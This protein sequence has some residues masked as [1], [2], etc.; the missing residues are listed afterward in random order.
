MNDFI[1]Q[2]MKDK[3][4]NYSLREAVTLVFVAATL[5]SWLAQQFFSVAVPEYMFYSFVSIIGAGCFGYSIEK[6]TKTFT[7]EKNENP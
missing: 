2:L 3:E 4:G 1:K 6:K 7:N 5:V